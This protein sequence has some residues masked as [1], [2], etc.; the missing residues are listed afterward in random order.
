[1]NLIDTINTNSLY[2]KALKDAVPFFK[3][4]L[5]IESTLQKEVLAQLFRSKKGNLPKDLIMEERKKQGGSK[6]GSDKKP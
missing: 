1:M 4:W 2:E 6:R 3:Y 5:W